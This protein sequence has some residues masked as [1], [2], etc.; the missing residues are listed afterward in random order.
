VCVRV[1]V[2]VPVQVSV[3]IYIPEIKSDRFV[4]VVQMFINIYI[5]R[6]TLLYMRDNFK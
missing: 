3:C 1:C 5:C 4:K 2:R 6:N